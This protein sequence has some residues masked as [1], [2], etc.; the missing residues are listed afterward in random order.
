MISSYIFIIIMLCI[1][2]TSS[3]PLPVLALTSPK[4][5]PKHSANSSPVSL[6]TCLVSLRSLLFPIIP[7]TGQKV[8]YTI[9]NY[10]LVMF[11]Q[12]AI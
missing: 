7:S 9:I 6:F 2:F 5:A 12:L 3:I 4:V 1:V 8:F 10:A 11:A